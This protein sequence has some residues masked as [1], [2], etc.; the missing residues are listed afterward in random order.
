MANSFVDIKK[1]QQVAKKASD[2]AVEKATAYREP[3]SMIGN[4]ALVR[5]NTVF[6]KKDGTC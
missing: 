5:I 4:G 6:V 2:K 1:V 3:F